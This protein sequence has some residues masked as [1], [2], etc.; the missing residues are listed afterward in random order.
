M[1]HQCSSTQPHA[2]STAFAGTTRSVEHHTHQTAQAVRPAAPHLLH[3]LQLRLH[4]AQ[5]TKERAL[6]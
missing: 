4:T 6:K 1:S 5:Q 2:N 3:A